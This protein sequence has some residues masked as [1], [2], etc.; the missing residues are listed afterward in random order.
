MFMEEYIKYNRQFIEENLP[1]FV[2][3][4]LSSVESMNFEKAL[5][6]FP[7]LSKLSDEL[8]NTYSNVKLENIE[9]IAHNATKEMP[10]AILSKVRV[11]EPNKVLSF[12]TKSL[13][14]S[15]SAVA[16]A[17]IL[18]FV[19]P[20]TFWNKDSIEN[21]GASKIVTFTDNELQEFENDYSLDFNANNP[22]KV[23]NFTEE[24]YVILNDY[25]EDF[26]SS[27]LEN[28]S[29]K[30]I[31]EHLAPSENYDKSENSYLDLINENELQEILQ[32]I[33]NVNFKTNN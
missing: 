10:T 31:Q 7:D 28:E 32:E 25:T 1:D 12:L 24:E 8:K 17:V 22:S 16:I 33:E 3:G 18:Y 15:F 23:N 9:R 26:Y 6:N 2:F 4:K 30:K 21:S 14:Y 27:I 20:S 13:A 11:N 19:L 29:E 5:K